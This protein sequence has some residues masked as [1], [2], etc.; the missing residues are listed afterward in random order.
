MRR[1]R[2]T[3]LGLA[4]ACAVRLYAD[5]RHV[6]P[7]AYIDHVKYL[8]SD[9]LEG[10]GDGAPGLEKA[11]D[12]IATQ[13]R[14]GGLEPA[15]DDGTFFQRF[16]LVSGL[17]I[18]PGNIVTLTTPRKSV[19]LQI[20][21]DYEL[22]ST[23]SNAFTSP[24]PVVFAGY[25]ISAS[26]FQYDDYANIDVS[27]K[28][29]LILTHEPQEND[30][31]SRFDGPTNTAYASVVHKVET[32]RSHGARAILLVD[33]LTH[34]PQTDLFR[35]WIRDPQAEEYGLPVFYLSRDIVQQALGTS[36]SLVNV[37]REIDRSLTPHSQLLAEFS[38]TAIDRTAKVRRP[39]RNVV[40]IVKG[41]DSALRSEFVVV[42]A[43]Y[44]HLGRS[45]RFS[46]SPS[47]AGQIH[48]GADDN[49]SGTAAVIEMAKAA[50]EAR[51][52]F[53]RSVVFM[54]FAGEEL[55]LLGSSYYVQHPLVPLENTVAMLNLDMVGR[56]GGRIL[57][58]GIANAPSI[59]EDLKVAQKSSGIS[60]TALKGS[61]GEGASDDA[62]FLLRKIPA[63]NFFSGFHADYHRPTDTWEK[64][65]AAGGA[66]VADLALA[67]ARQIANRASRPEFVETAAEQHSSSSSSGAVSGYGPYFGSVPDFA[68]EGQGVKFAEVR[69]GSPAAKAGFRRGDV[70]TSFGGAPIKSLY[71]FTFALR[72]KKPGDKVDVI[73]MRD[74]KPIAATVELTNRP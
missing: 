58:D 47:S 42:G 18:E 27:G 38:V 19:S 56:A 5:P 16:E 22:L 33:D 40:G 41:S 44:D 46:M 69:A 10:R 37:V 6:D 60:L 20:G 73:V 53:K 50:A 21:R 30:P 63:I 25:G 71:D 14:A 52:D 64:I 67:L 15:G 57:V 68:D 24:L 2:W 45:A 28:A 9:E 1:L 12:Y 48:H 13:F 61:P 74:G 35:R 55:G 66:A 51:T 11:A 39:V 3:G 4:A 36:L 34:A 70:L 65:D 7:R 29:V 26:A 23:S 59:D 62:A 49:A 54:T 17:S 31:K 32:A 8:A 72:D 43:H